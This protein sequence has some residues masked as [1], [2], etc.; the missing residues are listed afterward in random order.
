[1]KTFF[2]ASSEA[3]FAHCIDEAANVKH[4][5]TSTSTRDSGGASSISSADT[6]RTVIS[7]HGVNNNK[8][9]AAIDERSSFKFDASQQVSQHV[10]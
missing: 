4:R 7:V 8:E 3:S 10:K 2:L 9:A 5:S 6:V 1:L